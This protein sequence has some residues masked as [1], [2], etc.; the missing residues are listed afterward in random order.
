MNIKKFK[1]Y[2]DKFFFAFAGLTFFYFI[3]FLSYE[4]NHYENV[5]WIYIFVGAVCYMLIIGTILI[6]SNKFLR[7][8]LEKHIKKRGFF[9]NLYD[10]GIIYNDKTE[11]YL[12]VFRKYNVQINYKYDERDIIKSSYIIHILA[13]FKKLSPDYDKDFFK[14]LQRKYRWKR[15]FFIGDYIQYNDT[16]SFIVPRF[17]QVEMRMNKMVDILLAE[18]VEPITLDELKKETEL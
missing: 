7:P 16:F 13:N 10:H 3:F 17:N 14:K 8:Y 15:I 6:V 12:G 1:I 9:K 4:D 5:A 18:G 2:R 11:C